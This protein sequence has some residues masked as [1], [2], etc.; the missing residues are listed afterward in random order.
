M[1]ERD[2]HA[3]QFR[4]MRLCAPSLEPCARP[5]AAD[6]QALD[7]RLAPAAVAT[8]GS[9]PFA[10]RAELM[11]EGE[12]LGASW[13]E[14]PCT[15]GSSETAAFPPV[16][17]VPRVSARRPPPHRCVVNIHPL[18]CLVQRHWRRARRR[19]L[20]TRLSL[21]LALLR[22]FR[23]VAGA[24]A[25][26]PPR[27]LSG[28]LVVPQAFGHIRLG[29]TFVSLVRVLNGSARHTANVGL[30]AELSAE[31]GRA[32]LFDSTAAP[33]AQLAPGEHYDFLVESDLREPGAHVLACSASYSD[34][35]ANGERRLLQQ[36]FKFA[37]GSPLSVRTKTRA[38]SGGATLLEASLESTSKRP[39]FI[40]AVRIAPAT[41]L[42]AVRVGGGETSSALRALSA[43]VGSSDSG[44]GGGG[45]SGDGDGGAPMLLEPGGSRN[46]VFRVEGG[47]AGGGAGPSPA[48][49]ATAAGRGSGLGKIEI[50][51]T[52]GMGERGRLQTHQ[53]MGSTAARDA[54]DVSLSLASPPAASVAL[55]DPFCVTVRVTNRTDR[56]LG[57]MRVRCRAEAFDDGAA[58]AQDVV[59]LGEHSAL[60]DGLQPR[61]HADVPLWLAATA[62]GVRRLPPVELVGLDN[63]PLDSLRGADVFVAPGPHV[64]VR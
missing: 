21:T 18:A 29:E 50:S 30:R 61:A 56:P 63:L 32:T 46:F 23:W 14:A 42:R 34:A 11:P 51:W 8:D 35:G 22:W 6:A 62:C 41:G 54:A 49:A 33:L 2:G 57:A 31:R 4:V 25:L 44:G 19:L 47:A 28:A 60:V 9:E 38:V 15:H 45:G 53:I 36:H 17:P 48:L 40:E 27:A 26:R 7:A 20:L 1:S 39:L 3:L 16:G 13:G 37:A 12:A 64:A 10:E 55:E 5:G 58:Q 52:L 59:L 24:S 43:E